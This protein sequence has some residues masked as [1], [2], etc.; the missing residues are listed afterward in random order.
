VT[1]TF[2]DAGV[3]IAGGRLMDPRGVAAQRLLDD[4]DRVFVSSPFVRLEVLPKAT[5]Y[6]R[7]HEVAFYEAYFAR[8][9]AWA[10]PLERIVALAER[11]ANQHGL[12][13]MDALHVAAAVLLAADELVTTERPT[14]PLHRT[15]SVKVVSIHP[16][17]SGRP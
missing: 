16:E 9:A 1:R 13:A 5:Y 10:E 17:A 11:E 6:R 14:S 15:T 8:V 2:L 4:S 12:G 3:L 7:R